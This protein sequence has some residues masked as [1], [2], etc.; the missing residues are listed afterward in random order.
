[1]KLLMNGFAVATFHQNLI[2]TN[3]KY[4]RVTMGKDV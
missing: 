4:S 1:M 2:V 3:S